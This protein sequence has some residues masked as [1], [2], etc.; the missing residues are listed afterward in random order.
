MIEFNQTNRNLG[1]VVNQAL[2]TDYLKLLYVLERVRSRS[3]DDGTFHT[4]EGASDRE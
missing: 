3:D 2:P 4:V 1:D